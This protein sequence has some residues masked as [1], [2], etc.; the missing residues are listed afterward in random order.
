[1][2]RRNRTGA[3]IKQRT[4]ALPLLGRLWPKEGGWMNASFTSQPRR[5]DNNRFAI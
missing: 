3:G 5:R 1:M 4:D 2:V